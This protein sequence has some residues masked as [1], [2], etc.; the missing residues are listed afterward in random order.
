L[1]HDVFLELYKMQ[2]LWNKILFAPTKA[3]LVANRR[4]LHKV[5]ANDEFKQICS[6]I[7][8]K[9]EECM[10]YVNEKLLEKI[11]MEENQF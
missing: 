11:G 5:L 8:S 4:K 2:L 9:D 10:T 3:K 1:G 6:K 7:E